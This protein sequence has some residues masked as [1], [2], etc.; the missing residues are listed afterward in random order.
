MEFWDVFNRKGNKTGK[1]VKRGESLEKGEYHLVIFA[2]IKNRDGKF[3][4]SKR[5]P[6]KA[7]GNKWE[8]VGGS[9]ISGEGSID[10]VLREVKEELG[11]NLNPK[12]GIHLKRLRYDTEAP[13]LSDIW[14]F[15]YDIDISDVHFQQEEVCDVKWATKEEVLNLIAK[16]EFFKGDMHL[17]NIFENNLI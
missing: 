17:K 10:A 1:K 4:I 13:W 14:S 15:N 16:G 2:W 9:A 7:G 5:N 12:D 11:I 3:L 8:T 6:N